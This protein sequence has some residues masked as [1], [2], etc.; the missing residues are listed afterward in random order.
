MP[1]KNHSLT[2]QVTLSALM[3]LAGAVA[4]AQPKGWTPETM[5]SFKRVGETA[6]SPDGKCVV[7]AVSTP[8][9]AGEKSE[10]LTHL[11]LVSTD[12]KT[13]YPLT[14]GEKSCTNP[15]FSPDGQYLSFASARGKEGKNQ[16]Y[17]LRLSGGEAEPVTPAKADVGTYAWS[18][19]GQRL[20][21]VMADSLTFQ[22]EKD[23]KEKRDVRVVDARPDY[24]HL[25]T[26]AIRADA[27]G[28]HSVKRLT[29]GDFHV[30]EMAWSPDGQTLAFAHQQSP[31]A[32][33]WP[34]SDLSAV[35]ADG[36]DRT[37]LVAT[38]GSDIIPLYSPDGKWLAFVSDEGKPT[39]ARRADVYVMPAGG[40]TP[41]KLAPTLDQSP[42][43]LRWSA[44]GAEI[45][46]AEANQTSRGVFALPVNGNPPRLLTRQPGVFTNASFSQDGK[47][48]ACVF[49]DVE[50][51]PD[52]CVG[53][54]TDFKPRKLT[55]VNAGYPSYPLGKTELISWKSKDGKYDI[56]GLLTYPVGYRKGKPCPLI[57]N[58]HGGPAGV[59]SRSYTAGG[60]IYPIQAF[61]QAGYAVLRPN[62]RGSGGY[63]ADFR[64]ANLNDWGF[65]DYD[66]L[67][68]GVD[69]TIAMGVAH[70]DSL[71]V[72]GWSYGGYMTSMIITKTNRFKAAM[73][74]AG[75][76]N[77]VSFNGT[78]DIPSFIPDYF[79]GDFWDR[80]EVYT[81]HSAM[82]HVKGVRTP[83]QIIHGEAD[84]RVPLS[85]GQEL[86]TALKRLGVKT[87]MIVYPRTPHGPQEPK[88]IE[89]I[90]QR[91]LGWFDTHLR[92]PAASMA[93]GKK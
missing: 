83:T 85:Q 70:P 32:D 73:V 71:C 79:G 44:N 9:M 33:A 38:K 64:A 63:G 8:V 67:M 88:F 18:P 22:Q 60:S 58:I 47:T 50:T 81:K 90:G 27:G 84:V 55:A 80:P 75:V 10:F 91:T 13:N 68:A 66:D 74:G 86:Y 2:R 1:K 20:A 35:P 45:Y 4:A 23:Q 37:S 48:V 29:T 87:E 39:W 43:L 24:Q 26:V 28:Q 61:A 19:D 77:L 62:P 65:G 25:Y 36:G 17:L 5:I 54:T 78:A 11:W 41:R 16:L 72:T 40:G 14:R 53:P 51:P 92:H 69:Q 15:K 12:G 6:L 56:E 93:Q 46:L 21:F 34:T 52:V 89:D 3:L 57:L 30:T 7:Y 59:F 31:S 42:G 76:T 49:A 82:F